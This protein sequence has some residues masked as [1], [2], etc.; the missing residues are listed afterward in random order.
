MKNA[1]IIT[2]LLCV[3]A[4][5]IMSGFINI[6][7]GIG[8]CFFTETTNTTYIN[9]GKCLFISSA[10]LILGTTLACLKKVWIPLAANIIGSAFYIYT[11]SQIYAIPNTLIAKTDTEPLAERHLLTVIVTILLF[12]LIVFN[13]FD[14]KNVNKRSIKRKKKQDKLN[15]KLTDE[16]KII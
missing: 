3:S 16:E 15:R 4:T 10:F 2:L 13:Y 14:E 11:V 12:A 6:M 1:R 9:C 7:G 5:A 8:I